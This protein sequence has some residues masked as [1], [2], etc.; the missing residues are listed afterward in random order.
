STRFR[1]RLAPGRYSISARQPAAPARAARVGEAHAAGV[2]A[3]AG[4]E[5]R[6]ARVAGRVAARVAG[7]AGGAA[8]VPSTVRVPRHGIVHPH[9][10]LVLGG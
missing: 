8:R 9:L 7:R 1:L 5:A 10:T 3:H 6:A 2:A 4:V